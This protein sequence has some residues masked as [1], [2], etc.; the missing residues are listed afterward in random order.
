MISRTR[1]QFLIY[2]VGACAA[3]LPLPEAWS[4]DAMLD[5]NDPV[6]QKLAYRADASKVDA[7]HFPDYQ[8]GQTCAN[9]SS[10]AGH[11][12]DATG[13]CSIFPGKT[14]A[15]GGWCKAY[16]PGI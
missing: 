2:S 7:A 1:R 15:A 14:V 12:N 6:A 8:S 13:P 11:A 16:A 3:L 4:A 9:C 5:E 10:Y